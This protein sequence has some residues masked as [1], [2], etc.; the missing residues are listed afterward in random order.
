M[1]EENNAHLLGFTE[2][3]ETLQEGNPELVG[4]DLLPAAK[5]IKAFLAPVVLALGFTNLFVS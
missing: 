4:A 5:G 3:V 1:T 2:A